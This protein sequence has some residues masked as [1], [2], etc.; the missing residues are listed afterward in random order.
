MAF[1]PWVVFLEPRKSDS[2]LRE[3][4]LGGSGLYGGVFFVYQNNLSVSEFLILLKLFNWIQLYYY[5]SIVSFFFYSLF[6]VDI[7]C[8]SENLQ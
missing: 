2:F 5:C 7:Q 1:F 4:S 8:S 6:Y 3:F